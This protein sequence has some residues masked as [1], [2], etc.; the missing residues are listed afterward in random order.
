M[1]LFA[2]KNHAGLLRQYRL[3]GGQDEISTR[4]QELEKAAIIRPEHSPYNSPIWPVRKSDGTR[5]M[6]VDYRELNKVMLPIHAAVPNIDSLMDTFSREIKT[7]HCVLDFVNVFFS[8]TIAEE[9]QDQFVFTWEGREWTFQVL[10]QGYI[11]SQTYCHNLVARYLANWKQTNKKT[12]KT[13]KQLI[14]L[15]YI[16]TLIS[17]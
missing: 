12:K 1:S 9:S 15:T 13:K 4:V 14:M 6:M 5:R 2:C 8:I 3:S 16:I 10:P 11:H 17:C 7:Y